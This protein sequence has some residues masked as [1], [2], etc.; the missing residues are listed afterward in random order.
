MRKPNEDSCRL[1]SDAR[2]RSDL[3]R[4][5]IRRA[6]EAAQWTQQGVANALGC[7]QSKIQKLERGPSGIAPEE[8]RRILQV[9]EVSPRR[10]NELHQ[11][12][13]EIE[14]LRRRC[15]TRDGSPEWFREFRELEQVA[16]DI[17]SWQQSR[18]PGLLQ[19][20]HY[21]WAQFKTANQANP[22]EANAL[23]RARKQRQD[24]LNQANLVSYRAVLGEEA[25]M[26]MPGGENT[27]LAMQQAQSVLKLIQTNSRVSIQVLPFDAKLSCPPPGFTIMQLPVDPQTRAFVEHSAGIDMHTDRASLKQFSEDWH[28]LV[29]AALTCRETWDFLQ[30]RVA[31]LQRERASPVASVI[32]RP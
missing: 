7:S 11:E 3:L 4:E 20:E 30:T 31:A 29:S 24:V 14:A 1:N 17:V 23:F 18:I 5:E 19:A 12:A 15:C 26:R 16:T 32:T 10:I 25:L 13:A 8:L 2:L 27:I 6:R 28:T 21:M 9:L 22:Q